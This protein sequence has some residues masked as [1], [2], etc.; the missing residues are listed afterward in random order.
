MIIEEEEFTEQGRTSLVEW[1]TKANEH[2]AAGFEDFTVQ[3]MNRQ[4]YYEHV[5]CLKH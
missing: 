3:V 4:G 5:D 2:H 1:K